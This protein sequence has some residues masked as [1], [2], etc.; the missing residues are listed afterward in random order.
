MF[1]I[2]LEGSVDFLCGFF[3]SPISLLQMR[4]K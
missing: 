4:E 3:F 1:E 2:P